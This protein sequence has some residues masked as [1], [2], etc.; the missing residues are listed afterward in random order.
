MKETLELNDERLISVENFKNISREEIKPIIELPLGVSVKAQ[1]VL[2]LLNEKPGLEFN[3]SADSEV[4]KLLKK[5]EEIGLV[6]AV[7]PSD[8]DKGKVKIVVSR[9]KEI[10]DELNNLSPSNG[11]DHKRYGQLM[12]FPDT[13]IEAFLDPDKRLNF[14][15][16]E[17]IRE[18]L[19]H[20]FRFRM[21]RE[22]AAEELEVIKRW[23]KLILEYAPELFD[24]L[25]PPDEAS[26][27]KKLIEKM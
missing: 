7:F 4:L 11:S 12:G 1:M 22:H 5:F 13:A 17:K 21:S 8:T 6:S 14:K 26:K 23:N 24:E 15:D 9:K 27:F 2:V 16:Q 20:F 18:G 3:V 25:Y 19:P 10:I